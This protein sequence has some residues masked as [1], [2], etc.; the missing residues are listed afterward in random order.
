MQYEQK[1]GRCGRTVSKGY[2]H[3][4]NGQFTCDEL[5]VQDVNKVA[6]RD[7]VKHRFDLLYAPFLRAMAEIGHIGAVR[8]GDDNYKKERLS[9]GR[10]PLNHIYSHLGKYQEN[11]PYEHEEVGLGR[12]SHL[13]AVAFNAMMEFW[14]ESQI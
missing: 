11:I 8:Y 14:Y 13:A 6:Q 12:K 2:K 3:L 1:C 9:D 4:P 7:P 5:L 10:S